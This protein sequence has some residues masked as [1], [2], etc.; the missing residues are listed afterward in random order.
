MCVCTHVHVCMYV[1]YVHVEQSCSL[2]STRS[3]H[4]MCSTPAST[5]VHIYL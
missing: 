1:M 5:R 4:D 2:R 3:T